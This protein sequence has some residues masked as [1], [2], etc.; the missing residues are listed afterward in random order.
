M[1]LFVQKDFI[2]AAGLLLTWKIEG[3][4]LTLEDWKTIAAV[5]AE[6]LPGFGSV[7]GV[8]RGGI[9][10]ATEMERYVTSGLPLVVDDVW[11]TGKSMRA[12]A[13][14][15]SEWMGLAAFARGPLPDNVYCFMRTE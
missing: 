1:A 11:T 5:S 3:D 4:S 15:L 12:A 2:S 13:V 7:I 6:R 14:G 10:L 9:A 8:K